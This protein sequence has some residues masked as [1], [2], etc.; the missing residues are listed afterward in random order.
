MSG[1]GEHFLSS[2]KFTDKTESVNEENVA[3]NEGDAISDK[4]DKEPNP[5][6]NLLEK[7]NKK[8][9]RVNTIKTS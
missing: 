4:E 6:K 7:M 8:F 5:S 1:Q 9:Y 2:R 3:S